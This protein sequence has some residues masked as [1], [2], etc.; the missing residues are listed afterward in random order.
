MCGMLKKR[1]AAII[2]SAALCIAGTPVAFADERIEDL[3]LDSPL[4]EA[5]PV[6]LALG[7]TLPAASAILISQNTGQVLFEQ[8]ADQQLPPASITKVMTMLLVAEALERGDITLDDIVTAS[9]FASS[10]GGSQIWLEPGEE[11]TVHDLFKAV[12]I[13]SANDAATALAEHIA[14]S[15]AVFVAQM[16]QRAAELGMKNTNFENSNGLDADGHLSSARDIAIMSRELM[17]HPIIP[18]YS[19]IWMDNLRAGKTELVNTNKLVRFYQGCTGLKTGT[20]DGAGSCLSATATRDGLGLVAVVMGCATS[21]D[22]FAAARSLLDYGF[23]NYI[24]AK[25]QPVQD[26][27]L[28]VRVLRGMSDTVPV[29][30]EPPSDLIVKRGQEKKIEQLITLV[31]DVTAPVEAGQ[32]LGRVEIMVEGQSAGG[33]PVRAAQSVAKM[34]MPGAFLRLLKGAIKLNQP[35]QEQARLDEPPASSAPS[36]PAVPQK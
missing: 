22:R 30:Y 36:A 31:S 15:E 6:S 1:I 35:K 10:M 11:M 24:V 29:F 25:L 19:T 28:P 14:G 20:T 17:K 16:N 34:N 26:Q 18:E 4:P 21:N 8:N 13:S 2:L 27:L 12:A 5:I 9:V 33:Y 3:E 7:E 32:T 23:A